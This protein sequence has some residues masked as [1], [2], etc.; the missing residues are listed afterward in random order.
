ML[1]PSGELSAV[2]PQNGAAAAPSPISGREAVGNILGDHVL[3]DRWKPNYRA[4]EVGEQMFLTSDHGTWAF[5]TREELTELRGVTLPRPLHDLLEEK[6]LILTAQNAARVMRAH[7]EWSTNYFPGTS[8]H[9][10]GMTRRCN[11]KCL[12][13]H[14]GVVPDSAAPEHNDMT[15]DVARAIVQFA[16]QAPT[17]RVHFEFQGGEATLAFDTVRYLHTYAMLYNLQHNRKLTFSI[18]TNG[19]SLPEQVF[20][21]LAHSSIN[22]TTSIELAEKPGRGFR[23]DHSGRQRFEDVER[24]RRRFREKGV[25]APALIVVGRNNIHRL[26]EYVDY[27]VEQEQDSIFFSPVQ[28]IGYGKGSWGT[29]GVSMDEFFDAWRDAMEYI[30]QL[31]DQGVMLEERYFSLALEKLFSDRDVKYVDFRNPSGMVH[32]DLAYDHRGDIY[33]C[34]EGRGHPEFRIGNVFKDSYADILRSERARQLIAYTLREHPECQVCAYK[35]YCGVSPIVAKGETGS[36]DTRPYTSSYCQR[37]TKLFDFTV[38]LLASRSVRI[39]QALMIIRMQR[40]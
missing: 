40:Q 9:I 20:E 36:F 10:L 31:W 24:T 28:K 39:E 26:R 35:P 21:Y 14:A 7:E 30:F 6:G 22:V 16:F 4:R 3:R 1:Q 17:K 32:G 33:A 27:V 23:V 5:L 12:Y 13:C 19:V 18:V 15:P 29:V 8:L 37:T 38:S 34:D 25:L 11:L 2:S